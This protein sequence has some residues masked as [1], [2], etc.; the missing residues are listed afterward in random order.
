M[1]NV[2][3]FNSQIQNAGFAPYTKVLELRVIENPSV[4]LFSKL[5]LPENEKIIRLLRVRYAGNE[6]IAVVDSYLPY[7]LC[8]FILD[9][10]FEK[11]SLYQTLSK[12]A[13]SKIVH[14]ERVVEAKPANDQDRSLMMIKKGGSVQY[15]E[16]RAFSQNG[17]L[18]EFCVSR[19][20]GDRNQ[21][22]VK[23]DLG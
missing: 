4:E 13:D 11:E 8:H 2:P 15:F 3:S 10:N 19:Y 16:N 7:S 12:K 18:V 6:P 23:I 21:F 1:G 22:Y 9:V 14:V 17:T 5:G 20:R